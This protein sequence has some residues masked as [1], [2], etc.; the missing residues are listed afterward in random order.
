ASRPLRRRLQ[1]PALFALNAPVSTRVILALAISAA[2]YSASARIEFIADV[3]WERLANSEVCFYKTPA[4]FGDEA[5][6]H[7]FFKNN[8]VRCLDAHKVL[9]TPAGRFI[10]YLRNVAQARVSRTYF[11][12]ARKPSPAEAYKTMRIN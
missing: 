1:L 3:N 11:L 8:D 4:D 5:P 7:N 10:F 2:A 12:S 9:D 6:L